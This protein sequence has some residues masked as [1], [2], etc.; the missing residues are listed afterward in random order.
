MLRIR[1]YVCALGP[2][3]AGLFFMSALGACSSSDDSDP[4]ARGQQAVMARDCNS[5]HT[6]TDMNGATLA[7]STSA[8]CADGKPCTTAQVFPAN[9]TPD[10]DTGMA[11]WTDD[12]IVKAI[13]MG[14]DDENAHL[15]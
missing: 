7:G 4:V 5:C 10:P 11:D 12:M 1:T 15:C 14:V 8:R 3:A 2:T 9:L 6:P 13:M